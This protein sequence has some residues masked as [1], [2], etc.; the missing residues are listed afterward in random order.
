MAAPAKGSEWRWLAGYTG[1]RPHTVRASSTES[2]TSRRHDGTGWADR[3]RT[4]GHFVD[5]GG[6]YKGDT[7]ASFIFSLCFPVISE[8]DLLSAFTS[9][10]GKWDLFKSSEEGPKVEMCCYLGLA[11]CNFLLTFSCLSFACL[12]CIYLYCICTLA[13]MGFGK[14]AERLRRRGGRPSADA[15]ACDGID[16]VGREAASIAYTLQ[17]CILSKLLWSL[18]W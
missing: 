4:D 8:S 15:M 3:L 13:F 1:S 5:L 14:L 2:T 10:F 6:I 16:N 18:G 9:L 7:V 11:V 17:Q 12:A